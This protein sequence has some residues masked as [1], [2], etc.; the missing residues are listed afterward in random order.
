[1][2]HDNVFTANAF[3][4]NGEQVSVHGR[5]SLTLN[6]FAENGVGNFWSDYAGFDADHDGVGDLP[7]EPRSLFESL[8]A[9][10]PNLRVLQ[11]SPAQQTV[12]FTARM[13][14][15]VRPEP[16]LVDPA[17]LPVAPDLGFDTL[18]KAAPP[19]P[20][21]ALGAALLAASGGAAFW[22]S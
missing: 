13:L 9:R 5:G 7:Y 21:L 16:K 10:E 3:L 17:P 20:M 4:D 22:L 6:A 14:P 2:T 12:E 19:T 15:E 8:L 11:H 18:A 1:N